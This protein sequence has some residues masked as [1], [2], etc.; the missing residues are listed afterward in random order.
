M[1]LAVTVV[2]FWADSVRRQRDAIASSVALAG[3]RVHFYY[4]YQATDAGPGRGRHTFHGASF[5]P[6]KRS[7]LP[8][9]IVTTVGPD[10]FHSVAG[11]TVYLDVD[12]VGEQVLGQLG[13]LRSLQHLQV[14]FA[15]DAGLAAIAVLQNLRTLEVYNASS[16][17]DDGAAHLVALRSLEYLHLGPSKTTDESLRVLRKLP[18]LVTLELANN[19]LTDDGLRYLKDMR[20]LKDLYFLWNTGITDNGVPFL[21]SVKGLES[22]DVQGTKVTLEG[23]KELESHPKMCRLWVG[24]GDKATAERTFPDWQIN[25]PGAR[26]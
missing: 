11:A 19:F 7:W 1:L 12:P 3:S 18:N 13:R 10:F 4:G 25:P 5:E 20:R 26:Y 9:A 17:T 22:L 16:I 14:T 23:L 8:T 2:A 21:R 24:P 6:D 15:S